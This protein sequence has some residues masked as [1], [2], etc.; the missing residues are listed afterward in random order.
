MDDKSQRELE[1]ELRLLALELHRD[2]VDAQLE[3]MTQKLQKLELAY[4]Q[5][6][7]DRADGDAQF[8]NQLQSVILS[9]KPDASKREQQ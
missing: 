6:F 8:D 5:A 7:P 2:S 4:Y 3:A 1:T 9:S